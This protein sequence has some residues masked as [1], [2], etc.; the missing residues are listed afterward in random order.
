MAGRQALSG[1]HVQLSGAVA[2][3]GDPLW[4]KHPAN[5]DGTFRFSLLQPGVYTLAVFRPDISPLP[6]LVPVE[7]GKAGVDDR[8]IAIPPFTRLEGRIEPREPKPRWMNSATVSLRHRFG[9]TLSSQIRPDG[10]F[11]F[12]DVPAGEFFIDVRMNNFRVRGDTSRRY[13][14]SGIRFGAQNGFRKPVTVVENG[15]PPIEVQLSSEPAGVAGHVVS[16]ADHASFLVTVANLATRR[17]AGLM[18]VSTPPDFQF[19]DLDPG[20]Y[21]VTARPFTRL[22]N[23]PLTPESC[24]ETVRVTVRDGAVS[25]ISLRPCR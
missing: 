16:E 25:T 4:R 19:P 8:E 1:A 17:P 12:D 23:R 10:S 21:E 3:A 6:Y 11:D 20:D 14:V 22:D 18:I 7:V 24:D 9:V 5:S 15:N 13:T 2:E